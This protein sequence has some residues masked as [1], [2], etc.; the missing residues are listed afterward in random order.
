MTVAAV[1]VSYESREEL[2]GCLEALLDASP[3]PRVIVVDNASSDGSAALVRERFGAEVTLLALDRNTGFTGGCNRGFDAAEGA[4]VVAFLNPDVR[5]DR[6]CLGAAAACLERTGAAGVAPL[7]LRPGRGIVDSAG[8]C[9]ARWTLEVADRGYGRPLD[10]AYLEP[11]PVLAACGALAVFRRE[12]L[13]AV[14]LG[15]GVLDEGLFCFWEDLELGWRLWNAGFT[16][17]SCPE[18]VAVHGRGAGAGPGRGPLRWRRPPALEARIVLNKWRVLAR[19]VHP[20]DLL[21]RLPLLLARDCGLAAA[22][23]LRR[24]VLLR[25][26]AALLPGTVRAWTARGRRRRLRLKELPC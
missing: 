12:A 22:G 5:V 21:P 1:V 23:V 15:C 19:H 6:D 2:P 4:E 26:L 7:L 20:L 24:P 9:L 11:R 25:R 10:A 17:R 13:E 8:Q 3:P 14:R 18:A 16:V